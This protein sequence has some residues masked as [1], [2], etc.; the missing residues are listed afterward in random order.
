MSNVRIGSSEEKCS[1]CA[2]Y[3]KQITKIKR[4]FIQADDENVPRLMQY[5]DKILEFKAPIKRLKAEQNSE[6]SKQEKVLRG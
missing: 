1:D 5:E 2:R 3:K 6:N 4:A